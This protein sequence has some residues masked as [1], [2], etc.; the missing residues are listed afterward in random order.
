MRLQAVTIFVQPAFDALTAQAQGA[1][2]EA[3]GDAAADL[4]G[5]D[6]GL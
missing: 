5:I 3:S 2:A 1:G 4:L 6:V